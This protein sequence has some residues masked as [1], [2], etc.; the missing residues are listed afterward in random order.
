MRKLE[1]PPNSGKKLCRPRHGKIRKLN[2]G[3]NKRFQKGERIEEGKPRN[4][5]KQAAERLAE[6][7]THL[8]D[9]AQMIEKLTPNERM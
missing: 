7:G 5:H 4:A 3:T 2:I 6:I 9:L 8:M 1:K